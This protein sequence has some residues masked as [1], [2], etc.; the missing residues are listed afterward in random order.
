MVDVPVRVVGPNILLQDGDGF[1]NRRFAAAVGANQND[2]VAQ[3]V[4]YEVFEAF[5]VLDFQLCYAR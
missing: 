2:A 4:E 3:A 1:E 5:V